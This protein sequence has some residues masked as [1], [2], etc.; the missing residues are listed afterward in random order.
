MGGRAHLSGLVKQAGGRGKMRAGG[1]VMRTLYVVKPGADVSCR[2]PGRRE[3]RLRLDATRFAARSAHREGPRRPVRPSRWLR[4]PRLPVNLCLASRRARFLGGC[5]RCWR[6]RL[7]CHRSRLRLS[8][9]IEHSACY[10]PDAEAGHRV[11]VRS[12]Q[13][14]EEG[15]RAGRLRAQGQRHDGVGRWTNFHMANIF[16][17]SLQD[18]D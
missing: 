10:P 1:D 11:V 15:N 3:V 12:R 18:P 5:L 7:R 9:G 6:L 16:R 17:R 2:A 4:Q 8:C 13:R 14:E